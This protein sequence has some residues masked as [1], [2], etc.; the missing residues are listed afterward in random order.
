MKPLDPDIFGSEQ[1]CFGCGPTNHHGMQLAFFRDGDA[2]VTTFQAREGWD[3]APGI[4][5][6]GLQ[7]TLADEIGAWT[8]VT[9]T[10]NFGFTSSMQLR[11]LRPARSDRP[12]QARGELV[13]QGE[14]TARVRMTLSQDGRKL[15]TGSATYVLPT[16]EQAER[17]LDMPLPPAFEKLARQA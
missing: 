5:H 16:A 1:Q 2:V 14:G 9:L 12:I 7:A 13:E 4:V 17:I 10:G 6:G 8:V 3:G 15:L 11:Y